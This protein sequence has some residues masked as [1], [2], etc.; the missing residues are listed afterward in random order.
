[1]T[2]STSLI[3]HIISC[4]RV[5]QIVT[6]QKT[7]LGVGNSGKLTLRKITMRLS[8]CVFFPGFKFVATVFR[9]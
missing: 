9:D 6:Q 4:E 8:F 3:V 1:M 2:F 7:S 5:T